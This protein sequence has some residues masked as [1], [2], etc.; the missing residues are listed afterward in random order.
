LPSIE[1]FT[2]EHLQKLVAKSAGGDFNPAEE[3]KRYTYAVAERVAVGKDIK[4]DRAV[5]WFATWLKGFEALISLNMP[6]T[7]FGRAMHARKQ[8][9]AEYKRVLDEKR[10]VRQEGAAGGASTD[11]L[12][13]VL[14]AEEAGAR[15]TDQ[16][17]LDFLIVV[18]FAGHD[19][20]LAMIQ[21]MMFFLGQKS[22]LRAELEAEVASLW[23]GKSPLTYAMCTSSAPKCRHFLEESLRSFPPVNALFRQIPEDIIYKGY[24]FPKGWKV[25]ISLEHE[26]FEG[27][28][29]FNGKAFDFAVKHESLPVHKNLTFSHGLRLCIGYKLAKLEM[30]VWLMHFLANYKLKL[31]DSSISKFPFNHATVKISVSPKA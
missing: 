13:N 16:E 23:D 25:A 20:T 19:T 14:Q 7:S 29:G 15:L 3:I 2:E 22:E 21:T 27:P 18:M 28:E 8:L 10:C 31:H 5:D 6:F 12:S 1:Q 30:S 4:S 9:L 11:I 17:I 26:H 24:R